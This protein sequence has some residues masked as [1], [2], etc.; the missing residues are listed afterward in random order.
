MGVGKMKRLIGTIIA[1]FAFLVAAFVIEVNKQTT[2]QK[3]KVVGIL[4][5]MSHPALDQIHR[6]IIKGLED[7]GYREGKNI[8]IGFQNAQGDQS[9]LKSMSDRFNQRNAAVTIGIATPAVQ[10]LANES[11]DTPV[12]MGAVS[13]PLGT[14]LVKSLNHP[15]GKVTGVQDRQPIPAQLK[16]LR[17][18]LPK[19]KRIGVVYT[20][21][22]DSSA[23][24]YREFRKLAEKEGLTV[25]PYTITSTND[26]EQV[27]QTMAG[28]VQAVYVPTDNTVASGIAT[29][30]KVTNEAKIPVFPAADTMVKSGGLATRCVSQF[31]MGVLTG[32]MAGQILK[33]KNPADTP[34]RKV[35][36]Y[37]TMINQKAANE[38]NIHIPDSVIKAAQK[39]GRIIK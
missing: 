15:G 36:S 6:G 19:A 23:S 9:N 21:S 11:G 28:K 10:S 1:L 25:R 7:E 35:T 4:Q 24:E 22:D 37:E 27:A 2:A 38:L 14:H 8:Q 32:H 29:L 39:K 34:V 30:L 5:T 3:E 26:I 12:I 18:I 20:S 13:D 31:D 33:G 16:L 17:T